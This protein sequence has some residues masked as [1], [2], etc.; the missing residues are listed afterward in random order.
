MLMSESRVLIVDDEPS[1]RR[2][3]HTTLSGL[4]LEVEEAAGGEQ[5]VSF[6]RS[7][8]YDAALLDINMPGVGGIETC[9]MMRDLAPHLPILMLTVRDDAEDK[10]EAL[11]A[12][13]DDYIT[14]PFH[15]GELMAR[16]R[17][18]VRRS[19]ASQENKD[20]V[21]T[22][23]EIELDIGRRVVRKRGCVVRL[24]LKEFDLLHCLMSQAGRPITHARI[25]TSVWGTEYGNELEYTR[26]FVRQL[27]KKLEDDPSKPQYL[28]TESYIGYRFRDS[29]QGELRRETTSGPA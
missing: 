14:K 11:D 7:E 19:Q 20:A 22:I 29:E 27:R 21:I 25:L 16:V 6:V 2:A 5:A 10:I 12:G 4:G 3:L 8:H 17:A 15:V 26:T 28:L 18:A 13:A 9:R 23:G 1:I 24:T